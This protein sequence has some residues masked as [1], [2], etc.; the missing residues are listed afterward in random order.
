MNTSVHI[1]TVES[2]RERIRCLEGGATH[3][4]TVLPFGIKAIDEHLPE[5]GLSLGALHEVADGGNGVVDPP[6]HSSRHGPGG[7]GCGASVRICSR[8]RWPTPSSRRRGC[9][10]WRRET[11]RRASRVSKKLCAPPSWGRSSGKLPISP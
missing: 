6:L 1:A 9:C 7:P 5:G 10:M 3:S 8:Q 11:R 2:L 4:R